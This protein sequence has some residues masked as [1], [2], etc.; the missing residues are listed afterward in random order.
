M[1]VTLGWGVARIARGPA[2]AVV[3]GALALAVLA[4]LPSVLLARRQLTAPTSTGARDD[5][6]LGERLVYRW[7]GGH[8]RSGE[9][10]AGNEA[11]LAHWDRGH[12]IEW[13]ADRPTVATNFGSYL[14]VESYRDP[15]RF[16]LSEDVSEAG[17]ASR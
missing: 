12:V 9:D 7:V 14:G 2:A 11:V 13:V 6:Q 10:P 17:T 4:Q 15:P 1:A 3:P 5:V 8:A 16:F